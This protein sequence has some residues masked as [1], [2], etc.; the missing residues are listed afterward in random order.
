[1]FL[2]PDTSTVHITFLPPRGKFITPV[3]N[4]WHKRAI[5]SP[6]LMEFGLRYEK[7]LQN[8]I[9]FKI[10]EKEKHFPKIISSDH[11]TIKVHSKKSLLFTHLGETYH[12]CLKVFL[13]TPEFREYP[14]G[15][16]CECLRTQD[17]LRSSRYPQGVLRM[18]Q[19]CLT[20]NNSHWEL[21]TPLKSCYHS[22]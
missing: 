22:S 4:N 16:S 5:F 14:A 12:T 15:I 21:S 20:S 2:I 9:I 8:I 18:Y 11:H 1:M 6:S 17:S 19:G 13:N 3:C 10:L 7:R